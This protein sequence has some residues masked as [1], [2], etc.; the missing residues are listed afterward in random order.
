MEFGVHG[1]PVS[2]PLKI[3]SQHLFSLSS[4]LR[5]ILLIINISKKFSI[6]GTYDTVISGSL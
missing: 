2:S 6:S 1:G 3:Q 5:D 4:N